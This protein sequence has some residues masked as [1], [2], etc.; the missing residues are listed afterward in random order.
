M[1]RTLLFDLDDTLLD[2][3]TAT[4]VPAYLQSFSAYAAG[5]ESAELFARE[6]IVGTRAMVQN[7]D[8]AQTLQRA[9]SE[10]FYPAIG[11]LGPEIRSA[12]DAFY[13]QQYST[14]QRLV[15]PRPAARQLMEWA[16]EAGFEIVIATN[17]LFPLTAISQRLQW[18]GVGMDDFHYALVT[19]MERMHFSKPHPEYFAEILAMLGR[20]PEE[21]LMV[22]NDWRSDIVAANDAGIATYWIASPAQ[23]PRKPRPAG[24]VGQG[25]LNDFLTWASTDDCLQRASPPP[26]RSRWYPAHMRA[27]PG[28]AADIFRDLPA[29]L[30]NERP[31]PDEWALVEIICH[32][33]DF[34]LEVKQL[35]VERMLS[36]T[37]P[38]FSAVSPDTWAHERNYLKEDGPKALREFIE[39]RMQTSDT[40]AGLSLTDWERRARHAIFGPT[41]LAEL[42]SIWLD[43]DRAHLAQLRDTRSRLN[44]GQMRGSAQFDPSSSTGRMDA[45][46]LP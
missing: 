37:E 16:V 45:A 7:V 36:E 31:A 19:S 26:F 11:A 24:L 44:G 9:F 21:A 5:K 28:A 2:N 10:V 4:F 30:W 18:A 8:P 23:Q 38:F 33:R 42:V 14:L 1:I 39:A 32:L 43:H 34:E 25:D 29:H 46:R 3:D 20:R 15:N 17:P 6:F 35:R 13:T 41:H 22:G 12:I 27:I 40:L